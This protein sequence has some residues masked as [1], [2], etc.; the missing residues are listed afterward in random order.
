[1]PNGNTVINSGAHGHFFEVAPDKEVVWEYINPVGNRTGDDYGIYT[2]MTDAVADHFNSAFRIARYAPDYP[3]L[4][5]K[6]LTPLGKITELHTTEL[7]RPKRPEQ[8]E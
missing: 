2:I 4:A 3:G 8:S 1:M 5:G 7:A 6:D